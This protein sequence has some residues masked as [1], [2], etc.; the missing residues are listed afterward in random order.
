MEWSYRLKET[1]SPCLRFDVLYDCL[2]WVA[3]FR[4]DECRYGKSAWSAAIRGVLEAP[5]FAAGGWENRENSNPNQPRRKTDST[6]SALMIDFYSWIGGLSNDECSKIGFLAKRLSTSYQFNRFSSPPSTRRVEVQNVSSI[7]LVGTQLCQGFLDKRSDRVW[8]GD[9]SSETL[10]I[11]RLFRNWSPLF[12]SSKSPS[13]LTT[14]LY[15]PHFRSKACL[16]TIPR[17]C[18]NRTLLLHSK[19]NDWIQPS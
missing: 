17:F 14:W 4:H 6:K 16:L 7:S 11:V 9:S 12:P 1:S 18:L 2:W 5:R 15:I 13:L 10:N 3:G 8:Q 19:Q